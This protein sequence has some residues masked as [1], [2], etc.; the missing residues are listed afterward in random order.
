VKSLSEAS[1]CLIDAVAI[2]RRANKPLGAIAVPLCS[3]AMLVGSITLVDV[4]RWNGVKGG[5]AMRKN[6]AKRNADGMSADPPQQVSS[7]P[8]AMMKKRTW[9]SKRRLHQAWCSGTEVQLRW[10]YQQCVQRGLCITHGAVK[11]KCSIDGCPKN[12]C[13]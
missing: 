10:M 2:L 3:Y 11:P 7:Q 8:R 12:R 9:S 6:A 1:K 5:L 4:L 13:K